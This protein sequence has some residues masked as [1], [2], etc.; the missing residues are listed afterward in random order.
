[1]KGKYEAQGKGMT[2]YLEEVKTLAIE[3]PSREINKIPRM[4]NL[5]V[6]WL[7]KFTPIAILQ[8]DDA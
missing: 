6:D 5:E 1:M 7:S 4:E 8:L 2:K 3:L